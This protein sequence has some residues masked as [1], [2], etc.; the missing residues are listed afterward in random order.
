MDGK[1]IFLIWKILIFGIILT[2]GQMPN[3]SAV[4]EH[5]ATKEDFNGTRAIPK[6]QYRTDIFTKEFL[7][8][9]KIGQW[10][11]EPTPTK[12]GKIVP[13]GMGMEKNNRW[14]QDVKQAIIRFCFSLF[15]DPFLSED[16]NKAKLMN[17]QRQIE[18]LSL[19]QALTELAKKFRKFIILTVVGDGIKVKPDFFEKVIFASPGGS[20]IV[21]GGH[22]KDDN[23]QTFLRTDT[24]GELFEKNK[25]QFWVYHKGMQK[26]FRCKMDKTE[27]F[28]SVAR[29]DEES[30]NARHKDR[31]RKRAATVVKVAIPTMIAVTV[32]YLIWVNRESLG[33]CVRDKNQE[34]SDQLKTTPEVVPTP[35]TNKAKSAILHGVDRYKYNAKNDPENNVWLNDLDKTLK[36]GECPEKLIDTIKTEAKR[37]LALQ[38]QVA[39]KTQ[40]EREQE[41]T[42][43]FVTA[44][45]NNFI[46]KLKS[47]GCEED[48]ATG[49]LGLVT[50]DK[51]LTATKHDHGV[52]GSW[53]LIENFIFTGAGQRWE[54]FV[55]YGFK[56]W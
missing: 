18:H 50:G 33:L 37:L 4:T 43:K 8:K 30:Q 9:F 39:A 2:N 56:L 3:L 21:Q 31:V 48:F 6:L 49:I 53:G 46:D 24:F 26:L 1:A 23:V 13:I 17:Y 45:R 12:R 54:Q 44:A 40:A 55:R 20:E 22:L 25:G 42:R 29:D 27:E 5:P 47:A 41:G 35:L 14:D 38:T 19:E 10:G 32:A 15:E 16:E 36:E 34:S 52:D 28:C 51:R 11:L 7:A